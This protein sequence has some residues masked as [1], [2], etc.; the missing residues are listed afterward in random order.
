MANKQM[1]VSIQF[2]KV[3]SEPYKSL[4]N[5]FAEN[6]SLY[7]EWN[8]T[9][10]SDPDNPNISCNIALDSAIV[11]NNMICRLVTKYED[12]NNDK[13]LPVQI[14][15]S[16]A[17]CV[18]T[19]DTS[20]NTNGVD[21]ITIKA[22]S[23][24]EVGNGYS[25]RII[26][27]NSGCDIELRK[28]DTVIG[29]VHSTCGSSDYI[30]D[31]NY[32][33]KVK[34]WSHNANYKTLLNSN[35][36]STGHRLNE[37]VTLSG[38]SNCYFKQL[39]YDNGNACCIDIGPTDGGSNELT[40]VPEGIHISDWSAILKCNTVLCKAKSYLGLYLGHMTDSDSFIW[41]N[42]DI[43]NIPVTITPKV[44]NKINDDDTAIPQVFDEDSMS[45]INLVN[46]K[47]EYSTQ[48]RTSTFTIAIVDSNDNIKKY[49]DLHYK[50]GICPVDGSVKTRDH[51]LEYLKRQ[52]IFVKNNYTTFTISSL[53]A[54]WQNPS[55]YFPN[56]YNSTD[57]DDGF[58]VY[59]CTLCEIAGIPKSIV[60]PIGE[61][62]S[63]NNISINAILYLKL[64][65]SNGTVFDN[66]STCT[67]GEYYLLY[68]KDNQSQ[69][70]STLSYDDYDRGAVPTSSSTVTYPVGGIYLSLEDANVKGFIRS[71]GYSEGGVSP[72]SGKDGGK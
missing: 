30:F 43:L 40:D 5:F 57:I 19:Y 31:Y 49:Y 69:R 15:D 66:K 38:V 42:S 59:D 20:S 58:R 36:T 63:N 61:Y 70:L 67:N 27:Y 62:D 53:A 51:I 25:I 55:Y 2:D 34:F 29:T 71:N 24:G 16:Y 9:P 10:V 3:N 11:Y 47:L 26:L 4:A 48:L 14:L 72:K 60:I 50:V 22:S 52:C 37:Y 23:P 45:I 32:S 8:T 41:M 18:S 6:S 17:S 33:G 7:F 68:T 64:Y 13:F 56:S 28:N 46:N 39:N 65:N 35:G 21:G 1:T 12:K 54:P 44:N